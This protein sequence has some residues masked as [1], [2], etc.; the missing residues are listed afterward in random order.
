MA[1]DPALQKVHEALEEFTKSGLL[2]KEAAKV[3]DVTPASPDV[4]SGPPVMTRSDQ[5]ELRSRL[6]QKSWGELN[7]IF[8]DQVSRS[9]VGI[10]LGQ[11]IANGGAPLAAA[12][13]TPIMQKALDSVGASALQRQDLDPVLYAM[14]VKIF[15]AWNRFRKIPANGLVHAWNQITDYGDAQFMAE[16][17]T[18]TDDQNT[19]VRQTTNIGVLARR[20]GVSL[21][22]QFAVIQGGAGYDPAQLELEGGLR[23][24]AH[25]MQKTIFQGQASDSGGTASNELGLYDANAFTGLRSIL[26]QSNA[27][28]ADPTSGT[29]DSITDKFGDAVT[30]IVNVGGSPS[31]VYLRSDEHNAFNQQQLEFVRYL[32]P[33]LEVA[34]GVVTNGVNTSAGTLPLISVPGDSIGSYTATSTFSGNTVSDMYV[35]D[36]SNIALPYL[37]SDSFTTLEIPIGVGGQLTKLF[38]IYGMFGLMV[39][40]PIFSAKIRVKHS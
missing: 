37:G 27:V 28:N 7:A 32:P 30:N 1:I 6:M 23:A 4:Q 36:E 16:L 40:A 38:I 9:D 18:V 8:N 39:G 11:F 5:Y 22:S 20:V 13:N 34:P 15:P 31:A 25:K 24:L 2:D 26:N 29:P 10:P 12:F 14:F 19:Y 17:G 21:K 35:L 33:T 3:A